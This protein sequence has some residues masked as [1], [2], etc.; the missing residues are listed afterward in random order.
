MHV[1]LIG[2]DRVHRGQHHR[3]VLRSTARHDSVDGNL[4]DGAFGEVW[5]YQCHHLVRVT[6]GA[7][8]N[9]GHQVLSRW[10]HRE[11]VRPPSVE[12]HLVVVVESCNLHPARFE[13][14]ALEPGPEFVDPPGVNRQR[15]STGLEVGKVGPK[16][17][18]TG[19]VVPGVAV[20]AGGPGHL[21]SAL[22]AYQ[23]GDSVET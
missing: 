12:H 22:D 13:H 1:E 6:H 15:A 14:R 19:E 10:H 7:L 20:P 16:G 2:A 3:E 8:Q 23:G 9:A 11:S 5:R 4:L 18:L 17:S 21:S